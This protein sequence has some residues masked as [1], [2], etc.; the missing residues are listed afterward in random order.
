MPPKNANTTPVLTFNGETKICH[1]G[2]GGWTKDE[3]KDICNDLGVHIKSNWNK[4]T[5][6]DTLIAHLA[7]S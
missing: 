4:E 3:L 2:R 6:C 7:K 5:I 1:G